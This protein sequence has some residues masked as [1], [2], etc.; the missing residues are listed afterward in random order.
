MEIAIY[1]TGA[2]CLIATIIAG[3]FGS[4][5]HRDLVIWT[6]FVAVC[7]AF[8]TGFCWLQNY[9]W[10][11]DAASHAPIKKA[12]N[13]PYIVLTEAACDLE[14]MKDSED[15]RV[16]NFTFQNASD[17]PAFNVRAI[18]YCFLAKEELTKATEIPE[19]A[20]PSRQTPSKQFVPG[21]TLMTQSVSLRS[22]IDREK[23]EQIQRREQVLYIHGR[24]TY[25]DRN[26]ATPVVHT[27]KFCGLYDA[28]SQNF[29]T[30]PFENEAD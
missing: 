17:V 30:A 19:P 10:N 14:R 29:I 5:G 15:A 23:V 9:H 7:L 24:V 18:S 21:H 20:P 13:R 8:A 16:V 2:L 27:S 22:I 25:E 12:D 1:V 6:S 11:K 3:L 28:Q 26:V 4:L